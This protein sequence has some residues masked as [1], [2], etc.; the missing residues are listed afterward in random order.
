VS[1]NCRVSCSGSDECLLLIPRATSNHG[2]LEGI[3]G[4]LENTTHKTFGA[5]ESHAL[6]IS[7]VS[8]HIVPSNAVGA[9]LALDRSLVQLHPS[10]RAGSLP[11]A[12]DTFGPKEGRMSSEFIG[13][14]PQALE[15]RAQLQ[16]KD[17]LNMGVRRK[18]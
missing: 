16:P 1:R 9:V 14:I 11:N 12:V 5:K 6:K 18:D 17:L 7:M 15:S 8:T 10:R 3:S 13:R 2:P 4:I